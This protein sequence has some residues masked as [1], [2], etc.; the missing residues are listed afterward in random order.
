MTD[1]TN[2]V[3]QTTSQEQA[4]DNVDVF[5]HPQAQTDV[6]KTITEAT[7][8]NFDSPEAIIK[9][10]QSSDEFIEELK[11]DTERQGKLI[12][13]LAA[14]VD[15]S[16][17][18]QSVLE[19]LKKKEDVS[20]TQGFDRESAS[21]IIDDLL[22][23]KEKV[24]LSERNIQEFNSLAAKNFGSE[25]AR[26]IQA[27]AQEVGMSLDRIKEL[28]SESPS[29][30]ARLLGL[31]AKTSIQT[32]SMTSPDV[33]SIG[34]PQGKTGMAKFKEE[35]VAKGIKIGTPKYYLEL[36]NRQKEIF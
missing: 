28:A 5:N 4:T 6:F 15:E 18:A 16:M 23:S 29:A 19:Q 26:K 35:C 22:S 14:R 8:K 34:S 25:A 9:K 17:N 13:S 32:G 12:D 30:A 27:K 36:V 20:Q 24:K 33:V 21:K 1:N 2:V 3:D 31:D 10:I 7:G 11:A